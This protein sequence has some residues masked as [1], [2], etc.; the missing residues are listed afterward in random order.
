MPLLKGDGDLLGEYLRIG[1]RLLGGV[2]LPGGV[3]PLLHGALNE[4]KGGDDKLGI[5]LEFDPR[6]SEKRRL[7]P[8][9]AGLPESLLSFIAASSEAFL[10]PNFFANSTLILGPSLLLPSNTLSALAASLD[11]M[12]STKAKPGGF[13]AIQTVLISPNFPNS[14]LISCSDVF[15]ARSPTYSLRHPLC[16]PDAASVAVFVLRTAPPGLFWDP[17]VAFARLLWGRLTFLLLLIAFLSSFL[18]KVFGL[19][20]R[21]LSLLINGRTILE[22]AK[23]KLGIFRHK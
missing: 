15:F 19:F 17:G 21:S 13:R 4:D 23:Q 7:R 16:A 12:K 5:L 14:F 22:S 1:L 20:L 10:G 18:P 11:S 3:R 9:S 2:I 6:V 8:R